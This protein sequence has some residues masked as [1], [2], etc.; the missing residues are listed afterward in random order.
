MTSHDDL[1]EERT[2]SISFELQFLRE[3]CSKLLS[4]HQNLQLENSILEE[5]VLQFIECSTTN[6]SQ[7][8][9]KLVLADEKISELE[10]KV[11]KLE[12]E[13][14]RYR[15][16]CNLAVHLLHCRPNEFIGSKNSLTFSKPIPDIDANFSIDKLSLAESLFKP[17]K[18]CRDATVQT[19]WKTPSSRIRLLSF[20]NEDLRDTKS[21]NSLTNIK[22]VTQNLSNIGPGMHEV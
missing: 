5:K 21:K 8:E 3:R 12:Q 16:D 10:Q 22:R 18:T 15:D 9:E 11:E 20:S 2:R 4:V 14:R 13:K 17:T 7:L 6:R 1:S 19:A